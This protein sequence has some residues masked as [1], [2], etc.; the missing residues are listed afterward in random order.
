MSVMDAL[1]AVYKAD[2]ETAES[3]IDD[4]VL[5]SLADDA[6]DNSALLNRVRSGLCGTAGGGGQACPASPVCQ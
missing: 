2:P 3:M 1:E 6:L 5:D 4:I